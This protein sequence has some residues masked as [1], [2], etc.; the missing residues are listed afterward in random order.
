MGKVLSK[1]TDVISLNLAKVM[2]RRLVSFPP[3]PTERIEAQ[4]QEGNCRVNQWGNG[5]V[6][7]RIQAWLTPKQCSCPLGYAHP[8]NCSKPH[9]SFRKS[10][11]P[12]ATPLACF[13]PRETKINANFILISRSL[14]VGA[15]RTIWA[16]LSLEDTGVNSCF[17]FGECLIQT[18]IHPSSIL[19]NMA[20]GTSD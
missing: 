18:H 14:T 10:Q 6:K 19:P 4:R 11:M 8:S 2:W 3:I 16:L 9:L 7:I 17:I 20:S 1:F 12:Q 13:S 5:R 15:L